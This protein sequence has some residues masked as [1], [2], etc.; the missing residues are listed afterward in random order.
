MVLEQRSFEGKIENNAIL[1]LF[2]LFVGVLFFFL[3][4]KKLPILGDSMD[5]KN[6]N[7]ERLQCGFCLMSLELKVK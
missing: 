1:H 3:L 6:T 2:L 4:K 7:N 5:F